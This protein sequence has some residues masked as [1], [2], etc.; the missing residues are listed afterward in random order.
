[1]HKIYW[2]YTF[3]RLK[4]PKFHFLKV[5]KS[6]KSNCVA[7]AI[8]GIL[9]F[10]IIVLKIWEG[11]AIIFS[12]VEFRYIDRRFYLATAQIFQIIPPA[13]YEHHQKSKP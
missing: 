12:V 10:L 2:Y 13:K 3:F 7:E 5:A 1:M 4:A 6:S 9:E 11:F 8:P